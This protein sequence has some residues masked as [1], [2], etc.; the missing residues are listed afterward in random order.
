MQRPK[1]QIVTV[2]VAAL[3]FLVAP[4]AQAQIPITKPSPITVKPA[5]PID[6]P[7]T[8]MISPPCRSVQERDEQLISEIEPTLPAQ[9]K[10]AAQQYTANPGPGVSTDKAWGDYAAAFSLVGEAQVAA[11]AGLKAV[12]IRWSGETVANAGVYLYHAGKTQDALQFLNC[13]YESGYRSPYLLEALAVLHQ[14]G[15]NNAQARQFINQ[16]LAAAP[17]DVLIENEA[18][19]INTGQPPP[20]RPT[21]PAPD[22]LDEALRELEE[23]SRRALNVIKTQSEAIDRSIPDAKAREF[24][25]ITAELFPKLIQ[26]VR[27]QIRQARTATGTTKQLM[28]NMALSTCITTYAQITDQVLSFADTTETSGSPLLYW[29]DV[30]G[31]DP[32]ALHRELDGSDTDPIRWS[33][34]GYGAALAQPAL[35]AYFRDKKAADDDYTVALRGCRDNPCIVRAKAAFCAVWK[36]HYQKW[37]SLSRQRHNK[38]ARAFDRVATRRMIEAENEYLQVR[39]YAVRQLRKMR[40]TPAAANGGISWEDQTLQSINTQL[41]ILYERHLSADADVSTGT[42]PYLRNRAEWFEVERAGMDETLKSE[43]ESMRTQCEPAMRDLMDLLA[44][45]EWQ[46]YLDH[47][48]DRAL[49]NIQPKT[50]SDLPCEGEIGPLTFETDL[51]KPGEGKFDLKWK[52]K[53]L[54]AG[55]NVSVGDGGITG[56]GGGVGLG[57]KTD[58]GSEPDG[59]GGKTPGVSFAVNV[60]GSTSSGPGFGSSASYGPFQGKGKISLTRKVSPWNN[61]EYL[62]IKLKGSAGLGLSARKGQLGVKCYPSSGSVTIYPRALY[63]DTV[64]YLSTPA[65][66]PK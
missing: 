49:W 48:K 4:P 42:V 20:S 61:R 46:A 33:M 8:T 5:S 57:R 51:N 19:F 43:G 23:H 59:K 1:S 15:G 35:N 47:L 39:D 34:H 37:E 3:A 21:Q 44:Q 28:F 54:R 62:G 22:G 6:L 41:K 10:A 38:A 32:P 56:A 50:E 36:Q 14:T 30:L 58:L 45:E 11:W 25:Q 66:R 65:T 13:S 17:D 2:A 29:A 7:Q 26:I 27:D 60:T 31:L 16:A 9:A 52:G 40:F 53:L 63:E 55:G 24:E 12:Q 64:K 18:S